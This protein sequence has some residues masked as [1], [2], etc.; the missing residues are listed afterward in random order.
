MSGSM[1]SESLSSKTE[2][3]SSGDGVGEC[4]RFN[5]ELK[6]KSVFA[7]AECEAVTAVCHGRKQVYLTRLTWAVA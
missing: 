3:L 2:M 6:V 7:G 5:G 1:F 4:C